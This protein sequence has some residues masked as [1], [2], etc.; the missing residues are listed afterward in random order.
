[1]LAGRVVHITDLND[2]RVDDYRAI[3]EKDL[4]KEERFVVESATVL[5]VLVERSRFPTRSVLL[6]APRLER[7]TPLLARLRDDVAIYTAE[8]QLLEQVIGFRFHR[9]VLAVG[10]RRGVPDANAWLAGL[11]PGPRRLVVLEGLTNH[12]NVGGVFRNAAAFRADGVLIDDRCC[13]PLYRRAIRVSGGAALFIPFAR[14]AQSADLVPLLKQA[15]FTCLALTPRRDALDLREFGTSRPIP[16]R[17]A[18]ILGTEGPGLSEHLLNAADQRVKIDIDPG[19]DSLNV[20]TAGGIALHWLFRK[21]E[22]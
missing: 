5:R 7:L 20:G 4:R 9:G 12:D 11:E 21:S 18:V 1:M 3:R 6:A 8:Q 2:S 14:T 10:N 22:A 16:E 17:V 13:D 15:G 19:F